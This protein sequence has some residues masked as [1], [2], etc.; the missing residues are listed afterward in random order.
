MTDDF[1][2]YLQAELLR[3]I[4]KNSSYSLRAFAQLLDTHSGSLSQYL[5]GKRKISKQKL[6]AWCHKLDLDPK[7]SELFCQKNEIS[8]NRK[9]SELEISMDNFEAISQWYH[10]AI[11]ELIK[12]QNF[13]RDPKWIAKRLGIKSLEAKLAL[14]RLMRL[15]LVREDENGKL[16]VGNTSFSTLNHEYTSSALKKLQKQILE[17]AQLALEETTFEQRLQTT[18]TVAVDSKKLNLIK[19]KI[20]NF[21]AELNEYIEDMSDCDE[22]YNISFSSYPVTKENLER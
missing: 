22:V 20:L 16:V 1:R 5:A 11:L 12:T 13:N 21:Q 19:E 6:K 2:Q 3:R 7:Q 8:K 10:F 15:E 14:E 18:I 9:R 17:K 4:E